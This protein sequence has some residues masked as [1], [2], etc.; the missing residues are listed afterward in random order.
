MPRAWISDYTHVSP[1]SFDKSLTNDDE[2]NLSSHWS[3]TIRLIFFVYLRLYA[4]CGLF[5]VLGDSLPSYPLKPFGSEASLIWAAQGC[6]GNLRDHLSWYLNYLLTIVEHVDSRH[7]PMDRC[8]H[9]R[10]LAGQEQGHLKRRWSRGK[11]PTANVVSTRL[12]IFLHRLS[13]KESNRT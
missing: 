5:P 2:V 10:S 3:T 12:S 13:P 7:T 1:L 9:F 8:L 6:A 11:E 4:S